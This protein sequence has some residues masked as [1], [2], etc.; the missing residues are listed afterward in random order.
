VHCAKVASISEAI[1]R[2]SI[3]LDERGTGRTFQSQQE[4]Y[5]ALMGNS[6]SSSKSGTIKTKNLE[7]LPTEAGKLFQT[8]RTSAMESK[9]REYCWKTM[10]FY[11]L[12][13]NICV[14]NS[15]KLISPK[16]S[17]FSSCASL[18]TCFTFNLLLMTR[19]IHWYHNIL[20]KLYIEKN[21]QRCLLRGFFCAKIQSSALM[22]VF[23]RENRQHPYFM[24][25]MLYNQP[26]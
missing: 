1:S 24:Q 10:T 19:T 18:N 23:D 22:E 5:Q 6:F 4:M 12:D 17:R 14:L 16:T 15:I 3:L 13:S 9:V 8:T 26:G 20:I 2:K 11:C 25:D 21:L 7:L